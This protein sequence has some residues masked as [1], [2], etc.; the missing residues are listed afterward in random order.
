MKI[1]YY[2]AAG[3][4]LGA[5]RNPPSIG[6]PSSA[7]S[8]TAAP[9]QAAVG[10]QTPLTA[11]FVDLKSDGAD[12]VLRACDEL[13]IAVVKGHGSAL[14]IEL[15]E[16]DLGIFRRKSMVALS[17]D[18]IAVVAVLTSN[19]C[20]VDA[21]LA[22]TSVIRGGVK[23]PLS[24]AKDQ[25]QAHLD[26]EAD[27]S[28]NAYAGRL[29]GYEGAAEHTHP[30]SWEILCAADANGTFVIDNVTKTLHARQVVIVPPGTK[31]AWQPVAGSYLQAVQFYV[32]PGPEQRFKTFAAEASK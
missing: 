31:H 1:V 24:W 6:A 20:V 9:S 18:G 29:A 22:E 5:C 28:P 16:G 15:T 3:I 11:T 19:P 26:A 10:P 32:P 25:M 2:L 27:V 4:A 23:P 30:G 8:S 12:I 7:P 13:F 21:K 14:S 17:G